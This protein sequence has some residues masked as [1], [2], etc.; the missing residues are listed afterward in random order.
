MVRGQVRKRVTA[1]EI[2][3]KHIFATMIKNPL[4]K[5]Q[6]VL[7]IPDLCFLNSSVG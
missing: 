6:V 2:K 5:V 4:A 3:K 7:E 1:A